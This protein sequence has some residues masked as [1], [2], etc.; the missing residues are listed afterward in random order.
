LREDSEELTE[1]EKETEERQRSIVHMF[2]PISYPPMQASSAPQV[3]PSPFLTSSRKR[4]HRFQIDPNVRQRNRVEWV[5]LGK[6]SLMATMLS[7]I[8]TSKEKMLKLAV[9]SMKKTKEKKSFRKSIHT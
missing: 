6:E 7:T 8:P 5:I 9:A 1:K 3:Y 2:K 4:Y